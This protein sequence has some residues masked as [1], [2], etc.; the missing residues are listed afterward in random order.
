[1]GLTLQNCRIQHIVV[2][3]FDAL[4]ALWV[5]DDVKGLDQKPGVV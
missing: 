1:M 2:A 3:S 5:F 4:D